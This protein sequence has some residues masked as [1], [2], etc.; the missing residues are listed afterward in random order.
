MEL[1][2]KPRMSK[3]RQCLSAEAWRCCIIH[4]CLAVVFHLSKFEKAKE[5]IRRSVADLVGGLAPQLGDLFGGLGH[6]RR[7]VALAAIG[8]WS[9]KGRVGF[10][11][12]ALFRD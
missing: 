5:V 12:H 9:E 3:S 2:R 10:D 8:N 11:Q 1:G 6:E 7:F 4:F